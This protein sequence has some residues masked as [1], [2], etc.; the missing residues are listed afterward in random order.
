[1]CKELEE[2]LERGRKAAYNLIEHFENMSC[3][4]IEAARCSIPIETEKGCYIIEIRRT[5]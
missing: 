5:L 3:A 1:M 4:G 2:E